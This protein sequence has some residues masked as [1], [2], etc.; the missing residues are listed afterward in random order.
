[1]SEKSKR[2]GQPQRKSAR[3]IGAIVAFVL[4]IVVAFIL[5]WQSHRNTEPSISTFEATASQI[6]ADAT[7]T[8]VSFLEQEGCE[9]VEVTQWHIDILFDANTEI[10]TEYSSGVNASIRNNWLCSDGYKFGHTEYNIFVLVNIEEVD[11]AYLIDDIAEFLKDYP[12]DNMPIMPPLLG[13]QIIPRSENFHPSE[14]FSMNY[15]DLMEAF[16]SG[17]SGAE[18]LEAVATPIE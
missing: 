9:V 10:D 4:L 17:L 11:T 16:D 14:S 15:D 18:L 13:L 6:V 5:N 1:M 3:L 7:Q 12:P 2:K 8:T